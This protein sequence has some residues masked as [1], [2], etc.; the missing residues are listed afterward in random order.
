MSQFGSRPTI[1]PGRL[2]SRRSEQSWTTRS[3]SGSSAAYTT[4]ARYA[5]ELAFRDRLRSDPKIAEEY[6]ALKRSL[7]GRFANDREAYTSAKSDFIRRVLEQ[8]R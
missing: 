4:S 5:D 2:D 6:L 1:R 7:A 8:G 3:A